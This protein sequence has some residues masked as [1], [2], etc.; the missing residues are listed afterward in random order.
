MYKF[1]VNINVTTVAWKY[2]VAKKFS[3]VMK[4]TNIYY[5]KKFNMNNKHN[6]VFIYTRTCYTGIL[7]LQ[8]AE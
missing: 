3:W 4:P 2:F 7:Q 5:T 8:M 6:E 1:K